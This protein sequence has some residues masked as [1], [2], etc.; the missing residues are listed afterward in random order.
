MTSTPI[1]PDSIIEG[2]FW[3]EPVRVLRVREHGAVVQIEA[4]GTV[5]RGFYEQTITLEQLESQVREVVGGAHT[6]DAIP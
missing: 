4:V 3:P 2:P 5:E 1:E 6:F